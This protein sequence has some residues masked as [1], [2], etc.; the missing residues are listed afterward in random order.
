[1]FCS[2]ADRY[3][4]HYGKC[5][6]TCIFRGHNVIPWHVHICNLI[7]SL[8]SFFFLKQLTNH[9]RETLPALRSRLEENIMAIEKE[10][11]GFENFNPDDPSMKT[12]ALMQ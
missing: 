9:I 7:V 12:K 6:F 5:N 11:K 2:Y 4:S 10:V 1:M 8:V 3:M